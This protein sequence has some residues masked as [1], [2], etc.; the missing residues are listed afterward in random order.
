ML[1]IKDLIADAEYFQVMIGKWAF[2]GQPEI[3]PEEKD[4]KEGIMEDLSQM[5][6]NLNDMCAKPSNKFKDDE[7]GVLQLK[8]QMVRILQVGLNAGIQDCI[9][10]EKE[11]TEKFKGNAHK[12]DLEGYRK[13]KAGE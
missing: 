10:V 11:I 13:M 6:L 12:I 5:K 8:F 7:I 1:T 2:M 9:A 4:I 3:S